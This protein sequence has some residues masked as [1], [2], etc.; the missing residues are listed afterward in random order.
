M[1]KTPKPETGRLSF[2]LI[3]DKILEQKRRR[4]EDLLESAMLPDDKRKRI[5]RKGQGHE[6]LC[7]INSVSKC[8][9]CL[10]LENYITGSQVPFLSNETY[11]E[12]NGY[13]LS[14]VTENLEPYHQASKKVILSDSLTQ[15]FIISDI[16]ENL[17]IQRGLPHNLTFG[18]ICGNIGK[19]YILHPKTVSFQELCKMDDLTRALP[20]PEIPEIQEIGEPKSGEPCLPL[21]VS[22]IQTIILNILELF[23]LIQISQ[24][25]QN[26]NDLSVMLGFLTVKDLRFLKA[27]RRTTLGR[28]TLDGRFSTL[29]DIPRYSSCLLPIPSG[30]P[31]NLVQGRTCLISTNLPLERSEALYY[32]NDNVL[33]PYG[34][35]YFK[36]NNWNKFEKLHRTGLLPFNL[37]NSFTLYLLFLSLAL[38]PCF[39]TII[40]SDPGLYKFWIFLWHPDN[41]DLINEKLLKTKLDSDKLCE[42]LCLI[43]I[44]KNVVSDLIAFLPAI[45]N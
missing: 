20:L 7:G 21:K 12:Y 40:M 25:I 24:N 30:T 26:G 33:S 4:S 2:K 23:Q 3:I 32:L 19:R 37:G 27:P 22:S 9:L 38:E 5:A 16:V 10:S 6:R 35:E 29:I 41:I 28:I 13:L 39:R 1:Q 18:T 42:F 17:L 11:N 14:L 45:L 8:V 36:I 43:Y 34:Q 31:E 15:T 44:R